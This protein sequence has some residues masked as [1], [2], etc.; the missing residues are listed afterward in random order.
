M[1]E[2]TP[3]LNFN[4]PGVSLVNG[5]ST[6]PTPPRGPTPFPP[7]LSL[8]SQRTREW[9]RSIETQQL[10]AQDKPQTVF[11][12]LT[13]L[14][15][16]LPHLSQLSFSLSPLSLEGNQRK[17]LPKKKKKLRTTTNKRSCNLLCSSP[18][19]RSRPPFFFFS[20][21]LFSRCPFERNVLPQPSP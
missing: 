20:F 2:N 9:K 8:R 12:P 19:S 1:E 5:A 11:S 17:K 4:Q 13:H 3:L 6:L 14:Q 7:S 18:M 15:P 21:L 10:R 16:L